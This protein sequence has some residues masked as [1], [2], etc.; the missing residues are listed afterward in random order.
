[1]TEAKLKNIIN[2]LEEW[3]PLS[4]AESFDNSGFQIGNYNQLI[5]KV[6]IA[7][8]LDQATLDV[9]QK[10]R[11]DL[12]ITHHPL[13]FKPISTINTEKSLGK[14]ITFLIKNNISLYSMHTNLDFIQLGVNDALI[15]AYG[16]D[17]DQGKLIRPKPLATW[18]K[19]IVYV[20]EENLNEFREKIFKQF[21]SKIGNYTSCSFFTIGEGS[22]KPL[23]GAEPYIGAINQFEKVKEIKFE[24]LIKKT[25]IQN[26]IDYVR[27]IHPYEE[28]AFDI[29]EEQFSLQKIGAAKYFKNSQKLALQELCKKY[30]CQVSSKIQKEI[31]LI[32]FAPGNASYLAADFI[33]KK[34][35]L[36]VT[37]EM[38]YH[39]KSLLELNGIIVLE[40][41]HKESEEFVLPNIKNF[42]LGKYPFL[43]IDSITK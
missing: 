39:E 20:P 9:L 27:M 3:A 40:L 5:K 7:V 16:F 14:I 30:P 31:D 10:Q 25:E 41:G 21:P 42:L 32:A 24:F 12:V 28:P 23:E 17:P 11:F 6:L 29:F 34:I 18:C 26:C 35:D 1:M 43:N 13:L 22:F 15:N 38:G 8:D 37:G 33:N 19:M 2:S 4:L 36:I